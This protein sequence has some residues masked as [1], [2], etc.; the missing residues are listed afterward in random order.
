MEWNAETDVLKRIIALL[1]AL[2]GL[3]DRASGLP[4]PIRWLVFRILRPAE[5]VAR[6]FV[7]GRASNI[8]DVDT[9]RLA[10]CFRALALALSVMMAPGRRFTHGWTSSRAGQTASSIWSPKPA[11]W[12]WQRLQALPTADTS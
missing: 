1:L 9:T 3:A 8:G 5:A 10:L 6:E 4:R 7:I 11:D 12:R 2:A